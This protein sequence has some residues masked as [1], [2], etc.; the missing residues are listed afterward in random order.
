MNVG[1]CAALVRR[2]QYPQRFSIEVSHDERTLRGRWTDFKPCGR[3]ALIKK[4]NIYY[5][6]AVTTMEPIV[7]LA[8]E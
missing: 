8:I 1:I 5:M 3:N 6:A 7:V 4:K 2:P